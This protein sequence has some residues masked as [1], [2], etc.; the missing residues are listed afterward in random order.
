MLLLTNYYPIQHG[1]VR[2]LVGKLPFEDLALLRRQLLDRVE[3]VLVAGDHGAQAEGADVVF[4]RQVMLARVVL[5]HAGELL[6]LEARQG[7]GE[8]RVLVQPLG[9]GVGCF[10]RPVI[11]TIVGPL[12]VIRGA[13]FSG[14]GVVVLF[15]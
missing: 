14:A 1:R 13:A 10:R 12:V 11:H 15:R 9:R 3:L 6:R 2:P 8:L 5:A 4:A 7:V